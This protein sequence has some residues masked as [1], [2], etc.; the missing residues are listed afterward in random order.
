MRLRGQPPMPVP[1]DPSQLSHVWSSA[2]VGVDALPVEIETHLAAGL[3]HYTLVGLPDGAVRE[4][5]ERVRAALKTSG[6][7]VPRCRT[8]VNLAP[9]DVRKEGAAFDLPIALGLVA[10]LSDRLPRARFDTSVILGELAL[11]GTVRPVRG[12][13]PAA[14]R[15]KRDGRTAVIVPR[16]NAAEAAV[17]EG[18]DVYGVGSLSEA[19]AVL[20]GERG[21]LAPL[22]GHGQ[23]TFEAAATSDL[24]FAD[25]QG[26]EGVKRALEVAAAG[27]H[28][29]L[30]VGPPGSGKTMLARRLPTILPPLTLDEALET[31][32]I[33]SVGG[34]LNGR[35]LVAVRPV[36]SPHHTISDAG[37]VGGGATPQPGEISL[38]H[39]GV[40]FLDELPEF[41]RP[42]LEV[43]RQ[44]LEEG[45]V[46]IARA[47]QSVDF[48]ARFMLVAA[49]NPC[50]CGHHGN[51]RRACT[52]P[53]AA[54]ARYLA[55]ISGPLLDRIDLHVDV[56]PVPFDDLSQRADA[57][58]SA[59]VRGRVVIART[60]QAERFRGLSGVTCN[61]LMPPRVVREHCALDEA[62]QRLLRLAVERLGL[63]A[64][65]H[66]RVLK[67]ART[68]ADLAGSDALRPEHVSE[69][70]QYR[71]LDRTMG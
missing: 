51:P 59:A 21:A 56:A 31:T 42:V 28:N 13:L 38:A 37:L 33:H 47:R 2:A 43:L 55:R 7:P 49:M 8:T 60:V 6:L 16:A 52:C 40:L 35:G 1:P 58:P 45:R 61:A 29:V 64:R 71:S 22:R 11:D 65:A 69:A 70:I 27:G 9:A 53:P 30:M 54:V 68:I 32:A 24:D 67:V 63:S 66:E 17:V 57:E 23:A 5:W 4:S 3:P 25:V 15:A 39:H 20:A 44:P 12:V 62:S 14:L 46:T 41:K 19:H 26:Q 48:P 18:L 34:R 50:P 10:A 36:R